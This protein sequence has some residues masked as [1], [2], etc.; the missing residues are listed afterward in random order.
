MTVAFVIVRLGVVHKKSN[1]A[2][3]ILVYHGAVDDYSFEEGPNDKTSVEW[4]DPGATAKTIPV[5]IEASCLSLSVIGSLASGGVIIDRQLA[6]CED[7][8][9]RD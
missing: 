7:E 5:R 3:S 9:L 8:I 4:T 2:K 6:Y 1:S